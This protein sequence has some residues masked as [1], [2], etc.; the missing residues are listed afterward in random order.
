MIRDR[1]KGVGVLDGGFVS[2]GSLDGFGWS[3][4]GGGV[5]AAGRKR[6]FSVDEV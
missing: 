5:D 3:K 6:G 4:R 2:F 1:K